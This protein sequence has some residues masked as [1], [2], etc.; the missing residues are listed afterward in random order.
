[1]P[2]IDPGG[3]L[4]ICKPGLYEREREQVLDFKTGG[5]GRP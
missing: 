5:A 1:M 4:K 2:P 3:T